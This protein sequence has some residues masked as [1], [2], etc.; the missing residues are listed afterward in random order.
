MKIAIIGGT[1]VDEL[2]FWA[3]G[4]PQ[5]IATRFGDVDLIEMRIG[6]TDLIFLPRHGMSHS[7]P[8]S[9]INYRAQ[10]AALKKIGADAVI[11]VCAVG[12]LKADLRPGSVA[13]LSDF[14][15]L[16]KH[17]QDTFFDGED[18]SVT[19][20]DFT[21]PYCPTVSKALVC[22]CDNESVTYRPNTIYVGVDGP[23]YETPAEIR[24]YSSWGGDVIGMTNLP[25]AVLAREAGLCYGAIAIVTN[26]ACGISPTPLNHN[27]VRAAIVS[28]S[29]KLEAILKYAVTIIHEKRD[30]SCRNNQNLII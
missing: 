10:I 22:A 13:V 17:R 2:D 9:Q 11:S 30:C 7:T 26:L 19:H 1:G 8:P 21:L 15:D 25:E 4:S 12:S 14:I 28:A 27:E 3:G 29:K 23:R 5:H 6:E 24:L 20:T 16:T 18:G